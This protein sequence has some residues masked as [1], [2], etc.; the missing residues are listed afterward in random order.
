M[1]KPEFRLR[2]SLSPLASFEL[3][4]SSLRQSIGAGLPWTT[5]HTGVLHEKSRLTL[6]LN[7]WWCV[8]AMVP[9]TILTPIGLL[10]A[11]WCAQTKQPWIA[12]DIVRHILSLCSI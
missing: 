6:C 4:S 9:G 11:G 8:A 1:G 2:E 12:T 3:S 10:I 5:C 7:W